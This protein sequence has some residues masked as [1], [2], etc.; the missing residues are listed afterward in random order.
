MVVL[1]LNWGDYFQ[2]LAKHHT[3]KRHWLY[4]ISGWENGRVTFITII[5]MPTS[6]FDVR[7]QSGFIFSCLL[8]MARPQDAKV[9][10]VLSKQAAAIGEYR[11][12]KQI[13]R[14]MYRFW[15]AVLILQKYDRFLICSFLRYSSRRTLIK[16][17]V[18]FNFT[19]RDGCM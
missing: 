15:S 8:C 12:S 11:I 5:C 14:N 13:H 18:E 16:T 4:L 7:Y 2:F 9:A 1:A 10:H 17:D 3:H 19:C 6:Y